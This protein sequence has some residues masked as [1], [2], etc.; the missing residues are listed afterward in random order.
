[1]FMGSDSL[2]SDRI[3][4]LQLCNFMNRFT[5]FCIVNPNHSYISLHSD[6]DD[7]DEDEDEDE[8]EGMK[9]RDCYSCINNRDRYLLWI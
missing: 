1:M 7:E 6:N 3:H 4:Y 5:W 9:V 2:P 8:N